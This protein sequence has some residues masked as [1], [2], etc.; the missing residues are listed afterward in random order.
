MVNGTY[1]LS[2]A[3]GEE[4]G[5]GTQAIV[6]LK[7]QAGATS[8]T[9][10]LQIP[11]GSGQLA[12]YNPTLAPPVEVPCGT[13]R[14]AP[15]DGAPCRRM[16]SGLI[17][18]SG[19]SKINRVF[20]AFYENQAATYFNTKD[21]FLHLERDAT[22]LWEKTIDQPEDVQMAIRSVDL[23]ELSTQ[24]GEAFSQFDL[25]PGAWIFAAMCDN[26]NNPAMIVTPLQP[27][28]N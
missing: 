2:F 14:R 3:K 21:T 8:A 15:S 7:P 17:I 11:T 27:V 25:A 9:A 13:W 16:G 18:G 19:F 26:C 23:G 10:P 22:K 12:T 20:L 28:G 6:Y 4:Q 5:Q 1:L 24:S